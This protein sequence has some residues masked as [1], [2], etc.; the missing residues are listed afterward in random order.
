MRRRFTKW[1]VKKGYGIG[2]YDIGYGPEIGFYLCP[3]WVEILAIFL[4]SP[5]VYFAN[6]VFDEGGKT[7]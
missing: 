6:T 3:W 4:F 5:S 2:Y 1:Y 7:E